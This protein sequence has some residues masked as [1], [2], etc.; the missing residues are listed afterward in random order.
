VAPHHCRARTRAIRRRCVTPLQGVETRRRTH[1]SL[2]TPTLGRRVIRETVTSRGFVAQIDRAEHMLRAVDELVTG[3]QRLWLAI[4]SAALHWTWSAS[5]HPC[6]RPKRSLAAALCPM[7]VC[8]RCWVC[9]HK[10][11]QQCRRWTVQGR[12]V[13]PLHEFNAAAISSPSLHYHGYKNASHP[14]RGFPKL[15]TFLLVLLH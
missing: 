4:L 15:L 2:Q 8:G 3:A 13:S 5:K 6:P 10:P 14:D 11:S 7:A 9:V 12:V 1:G